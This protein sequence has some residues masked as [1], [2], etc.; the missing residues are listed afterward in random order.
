MTYSTVAWIFFILI[1]L[2]IFSTRQ[3]N[4]R[5]RRFLA[6]LEYRPLQKV[7]PDTKSKETKASAR[8]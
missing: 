8:D 1:I 6:D 7:L 4:K 2:A 5:P 3:L